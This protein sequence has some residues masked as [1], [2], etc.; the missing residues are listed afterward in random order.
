M[1]REMADA[2]EAKEKLL[3]EL[4][5]SE[6]PF[7]KDLRT[8]DPE[9]FRKYYC[10][11]EAQGILER[12]AFD[13]KAC[14]LYGP[15]GVGKTSA[16]YYVMFSLPENEFET[17]FFKEPPKSMTALAL[18]TGFVTEGGF[19]DS[20]FE[21]LGK[22]RERKVSRADVVRMLKKRNK[23]V[24]FF[25]DEAHLNEEMQMEWKYLLDDVPNLRIVLSSLGSDFPDSLMHLIG[26]GNVLQRRGFND[27]E[28][29]RI[30]SHRISAVGGSGMRP[31]SDSYLKGM[32]TEKNL[33]SPRY[34]F[35]ELNLHLAS[36]AGGKNRQA[37]Y[38]GDSIVEAV[39][40]EGS[41]E[42]L[43]KSNA[44]WW[45][46]LSPSQRSILELLIKNREGMT[47]AEIMDSTKLQENTSFNALYQL[48]G[49]DEAEKK[50]KPEVPF[51]L[52]EVET[53]LVGG[54]KRNIYRVEPK[55]RS[56]FTMT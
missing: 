50:R 53:K 48:R 11:F 20:L 4:G 16:L 55:V 44:E 31:F 47:L 12:L 17:Y 40:A 21:L 41:E 32:L 10:P 2:F 29:K 34:V 49:E 54:R 19:V 7:V 13:A 3:K 30:I 38:V 45:V 56:I 51:P 46:Q 18:E 5:W 25:V 37:M 28:M 8:S 52:V 9:G 36:I 6:N 39:M 14:L 1:N 27:E 22:K 43:S 24:V 42:K 33:L 23:K 15:K 35:D 26:E